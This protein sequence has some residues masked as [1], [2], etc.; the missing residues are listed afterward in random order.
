MPDIFT[1]CYDQMDSL[2]SKRDWDIVSIQFLSI[3]IWI[4]MPRVAMRSAYFFCNEKKKRA[5]Y[6]DIHSWSKIRKKIIGLVFV[7]RI[8]VVISRYPTRGMVFSLKISGAEEL[9]HLRVENLN[10]QEGSGLK[11]TIDQRSVIAVFLG[12]G[13][14][15]ATSGSPS[16][17]T[18]HAR[19]SIS[20]S[21]KGFRRMGKFLLLSS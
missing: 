16:T 15:T 17:T 14:S 8:F 1:L 10:R 18:G 9:S 12:T 19:K 6:G 3:T 7:G 5:W 13:S 2:S 21:Y 20:W 4:F 11:L